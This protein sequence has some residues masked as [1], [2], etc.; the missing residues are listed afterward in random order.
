MG[1]VVV[2][3]SRE[4][5]AQVAE[6]IFGLTVVWEAGVPFLRHEV[7]PCPCYSSDIAD[8]WPVLLEMMGRRFSVRNAFFE[9]LTEEGNLGKSLYPDGIWLLQVLKDR[10]PEAI[11]KSALA[12]VNAE[13]PAL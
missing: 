1:S 11:C 9:A 6:K 4:L 8:G 5:D 13:V 2:N 10:M 3:A 12:A 7:S